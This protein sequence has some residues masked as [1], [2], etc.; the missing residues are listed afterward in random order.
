MTIRSLLL[1][2]SVA[3][4]LA[5][6]AKEDDSPQEGT[7]G[8]T[9][10]PAGTTGTMNVSLK[11]AIETRADQEYDDGEDSESRAQDL[12]I[13]FFDDD[14][15]YLGSSY[16][17]D[18]SQEDDSKDDNVTSTITVDVP[19]NIVQT[20]YESSD[21]EA[22]MYVVAV[23]NK[24]TFTPQIT[25]GE[26]YNVFNAAC[27]IALADAAKTNNF[28]M[29]SSNYM[30]NINGTQTEMALTPITNKN[31][32]L[33][34]DDQTTSPDPVTIAVERVVAK[35]TVQDTETRPTDGATWTI[36]GWGLNV[37]NKTFYPVKNFG[38]DQFLDLL[39]SKYNT[40]QPNTSNK[41]WN[42]PTDMRS[43]WAVDP[44][45]AAGQAT[46]TD[47]P[48]DFNEFSFSDPSSAEVKGALYCFENTTVETMQQRNATTSAV[49]VAQF[50]PKDFKEADKA[51]SWIKWNDAAYSKE[52]DYATFVEKVVEDVDG[53]NQVITKYYKLDTNGTTTGNDGKKYSP[54][55]EEDFICTY[56]T[57]GKEK[58]TF[59]KKNT[60]IGYKDAEL[61]VALRDSEI[62]LYAIT[63]DQASEVTSA[64]VEINKAI[65]KALTDNPP[66]VYYNG[67]CYY[68]V[69]IRHFAK[70]EVAEYTG[71]EYQSNHLGRY[72]IVRNNYYQITINDI[73]Q[74]GEPITDPTVDPSTDKDD[75]TNYWIKVSIKVLSWKIRTQNV[76][77]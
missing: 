30:G 45:Y 21:K 73:T 9:T 26:N 57:E 75:E 66:T 50:Y 70:G 4:L 65:A 76:I 55:S 74:P 52:N 47:M 31:V 5:G 38:G 46:I 8:T 27:R 16:V 2:A 72:G 20:L 69:P 6:C 77:L 42:N 43:H 33:K 49:I 17:S 39:A 25:A 53:D 14:K 41:P 35:V 68:V 23:L 62:R 1:A 18:L 71:G 34:S 12:T 51:G 29:T 64:P 44:N 24:G 7:G 63:D 13:Y 56:T 11:Y 22:T 40:W 61:Q 28:M 15:N 67:Y 58:I 19:T 32:G 48:N 54:L 59:G 36:L 37:T 60:T 10:V 3:A